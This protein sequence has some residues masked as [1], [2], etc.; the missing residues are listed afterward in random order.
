MR[1]GSLEK[2]RG[3]LTD[4]S[5]KTP[6]FAYTS[7]SVFCSFHFITRDSCMRM[8]SLLLRRASAPTAYPP[9]E[10]IILRDIKIVSR[11][12][13]YNVIE[14][15]DFRCRICSGSRCSLQRKKKNKTLQKSC[16]HTNVSINKIQK[17]KTSMTAKTVAKYKNS[18]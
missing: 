17:K 13:N 9:P 8:E 14:D 11:A 12:T 2:S 7:F 1:T 16:F 10:V 15:Y 18:F 3:R 4:G 6:G 5:W